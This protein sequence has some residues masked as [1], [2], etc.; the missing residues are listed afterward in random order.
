M[1]TVTD[2]VAEGNGIRVTY[3]DNTVDQF[4]IKFDN[5]A[6]TIFRNGVQAPFSVVKNIFDTIQYNSALTSLYSHL[7]GTAADHLVASA[8]GQI[9]TPLA[10]NTWETLIWDR[11]QLET[12]NGLGL[13]TTTGIISFPFGEWDIDARAQIYDSSGAS[14]STVSIHAFN[15]D[16]GKEIPF[17]FVTSSIVA[18]LN[19]PKSIN[20]STQLDLTDLIEDQ[21][22]RVAIQVRS[23]NSTTVFGVHSSFLPAGSSNHAGL[24]RISRIG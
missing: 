13:N 8:V 20:T 24:L 5:G 3:D 18:K 22:R 6:L 1:A 21:V 9:N 19:G 23:N 16:T 11:V 17:S 10:I 14:A 12:H 2:I 7:F 15:V 4:A